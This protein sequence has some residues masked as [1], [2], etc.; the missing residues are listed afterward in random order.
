ML[1]QTDRER[2]HQARLAQINRVQV[3]VGRADRSRIDHEGTLLERA[4]LLSQEVDA[5]AATERGLDAF[6]RLL[7]LAEEEPHSRAGQHVVPFL[8]AVWNG[9]PL[10]IAALRVPAPAVADDMLAV[11]DAYRHARLNI[12]DQVEGGAERVARLLRRQRER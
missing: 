11:L 8:A 1:S 7:R 9:Q 10:P 3:V 2:R 4:R 12:A 5:H 6:A